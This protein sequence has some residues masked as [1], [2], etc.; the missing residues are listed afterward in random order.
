VALLAGVSVSSVARICRAEKL[1]RLHSLEPL[2][3]PIRYERDRPGELIHLDTKRLGRF[4]RVGHRITRTRSHGS[5][6]Q[7]FEFVY[8]ATDD[9]SRLSYAEILADEFGET[10]A[11]FFLRA[12]AWFRRMK[13]VVERAMTDN[14]SPF[15]SGAFRDACASVNVRHIRTRPYTPRTNGKVERFIQ[16]MLREWAYRFTYQSSAERRYWL[17]PYMHFYNYHR[18]H[19]AL[20]YNP[21]ISRLDRNNVLRNNS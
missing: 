1:S 14:G 18:A 21:P 20:G 11:G 9:A 5:S 8:V 10:A 12:V 3:P 4:D 13:I 15:L 6:R 16:T 19:S 17:K 2:P 7:G